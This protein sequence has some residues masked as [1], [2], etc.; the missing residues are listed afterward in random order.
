MPGSDTTEL[1]IYCVCG[2]KMRVSEDMFGRPGKCV[3]CRQKIRIPRLDEMPP[4]TTELHLKD[5]PQ[6]LRKVKKRPVD[7]EP[8][9]PLEE[10]EMNLEGEVPE[11]SLGSVPI[12]IL[13]SQRLLM[14]LDEKAKRLLDGGSA[15][16]N[17]PSESDLKQYRVRIGDALADLEEELRQRLME[18]AI[19]LATA[20]DTIG[21]LHLAVRVGEMTFSEYAAQVDRLRRRRDIMELRQVNLRGWLAAR[22]AAAAGG[23]VEAGFDQIPSGAIRVGFIRE[24]DD[25]ALLLDWH[26]E[27][28]RKA[29]AQRRETEREFQEYT[30][31]RGSKNGGSRRDELRAAKD[32]ALSEVQYYR[33]RLD[34][35]ARDYAGDV[36]AVDAQLDHAR[37][38]L[39]VGTIN[40][41][42]FASIESDLI[43]A[44]TDHA[45]ARRLVARALGANSPDEVPHPRGTFLER[46]AQSSNSMR[47]PFDAWLAW[48]S[49]VVLVVSLF[50]PLAGNASAFEIFRTM[51]ARD[52]DAHWLVSFPATIALLITFLAFVPQQS[53]RGLVICGVWII[54]CVASA[55][56]VHESAYLDSATG[57]RL[58]E[59]GNLLLQPGMLLY[60]AGLAGIGL[61]SVLSLA[62]LREVR[63]MLPLAVV[64]TVAAIAII[65][66]EIGGLR[67][68]RPAVTTGQPTFV[69]DNVP[70]SFE[71][72]V[73]I[74]NEG[75]RFMLL[76]SQSTLRNAYDLLLERKIGSDSWEDAGPP[77]AFRTGD[78]PRPMPRSGVL[79]GIPLQPTESATF[80]Y[81]LPPGEYRVQLGSKITGWRTAET[82]SLIPP[83]DGTAQS[84]A[85]AVAPA[86]QAPT[87]DSAEAPSPDSEPQKVPSVLADL[88][89]AQVQLRGIIAQAGRDASFSIQVILPDGRSQQRTFN[90]GDEVHDGWTVSEFNPAEQTVTLKKDDTILILRQRPEPYPLRP[91]SL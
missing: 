54:G 36:Q 64:L 49:A 21:E 82:F 58:R 30:S 71:T 10:R 88:L 20:N 24:L 33:E 76:S 63:A 17:A 16:E 91:P 60:I 28:L 25:S 11:S 51:T 43:R 53:A 46:L 70:P 1:R 35:L 3:A 84:A 5:H 29:L 26:I 68:P 66:T 34:Q 75:R 81:M 31:N 59:G 67:T 86:P 48:A 77:V 12:E 47:V 85:P 18:S 4:N 42:Q 89:T 27:G 55:A 23:Y 83:G 8:P 57:E 41:A 22:T 38:R 69:R 37:N 40:S 14:S 19:E 39:K 2:Q 6:F 50:L 7:S 72:P 13:E 52:V 80:T 15:G 65:V 32:R 87:P 79:G 74:T 62:P 56:Y 90:V 78:S 73:R 9:P 45:K 61:S 44:K